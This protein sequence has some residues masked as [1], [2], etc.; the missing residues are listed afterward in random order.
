MI[1]YIIGG[2]IIAAAFLVIIA[3]KMS[4]KVRTY[5]IC[6]KNISE[7]INGEVSIAHISDLHESRFGNGQEKLLSVL[8]RACPD[9]IFITG[10]MLEDRKLTENGEKL[11]FDDNS[12][13]QLISKLSGI[14]PTYMVL[15]NHD[16]N[17]TNISE[18][19]QKIE[20]MGIK[21]LSK[22]QKD[23][24][25][26]YS[27]KI[28]GQKLFILGVDDPYLDRE[29]NISRK[30]TVKDRFLEDTDRNNK[31]ITDW[32]AALYTR[33]K[34]AIDNKGITILLSHRPEEYELY[35]RI[36]YD[37][38]FSGH[39]HGGQWRLPPFINGVYAPHQGV[40][41]K[42]AGGLYRKNDFFHVVSRGLSKK[43]MVRIF[44]PPE[45]CV[46]KLTK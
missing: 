23:K 26:S 10:D 15:G 14:A 39:A 8:K 16:C 42:H 7:E 31:I 11:I 45:I 37:L 21:I 41:P 27:V 12:S 35:E 34:N 29:G 6:P 36:G 22:I 20:D 40:F 24:I 1:K 44:N 17:I 19:C 3:F 18:I 38:A 9:I 28:K 2:A 13:I 32:R 43:R 25:T 4:I 33:D 30:K 5:K 46:V